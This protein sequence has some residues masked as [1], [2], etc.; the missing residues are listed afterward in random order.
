MPK[1]LNPTF[2]RGDLFT[3]KQKVP[4]NSIILGSD[5]QV[6]HQLN[7]LGNSTSHQLIT[8]L[9]VPRNP[10]QLKA[11]STMRH[12]SNL[13]LKALRLKRYALKSHLILFVA[14][15]EFLVEFDVFNPGQFK[16]RIRCI[17]FVTLCVILL[18]NATVKIF[19]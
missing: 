9:E 10:N 4:K 11:A 15:I 18:K 1:C 5:I 6:L 12:G 7:C 3:L 19:L 8:N 14:Q 13:Q 16:R 2:R 17:G